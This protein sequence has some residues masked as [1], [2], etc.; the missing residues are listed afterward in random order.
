M[1]LINLICDVIIVCVFA[2][3]LF[4]GYKSGF[5]KTAFRP[6]KIYAF[7]LAY[8][9]YQVLSDRICEQYVVPFVHTKIKEAIGSSNLDSSALSV[10]S[11][12]SS[13]PD[14]VY[15]IAEICNLDIAQL[16]QKAIDGSENAVA[17]FITSITAYVA[18]LISVIISFIVIYIVSRFALRIAEF[19]LQKIFEA[20]ILNIVNRIGGLFF[21]IISAFLFSLIVSYIIAYGVGALAESGKYA[22]I[23]SFN[24]ENTKIVKLFFKFNIFDL[25]S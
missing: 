8:K 22:F 25:F 6:K 15:K 10:N 17:E 3:F 18:N 2:F 20:K 16:A 14:F 23:S 13:I 11:L 7:I 5:I 21:G 9:F 12:T 24:V 4:R 19:I 1:S